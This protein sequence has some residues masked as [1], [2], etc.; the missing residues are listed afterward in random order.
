MSIKFFKLANE[1][2]VNASEVKRLRI[3]GRFKVVGVMGTGDADLGDFDSRLEAEEFITSLCE[4]VNISD[5]S[6]EAMKQAT[7]DVYSCILNEFTPFGDD[8]DM[9][10]VRDVSFEDI[11]SRVKD[12]YTDRLCK[13]ALKTLIEMGHVYHPTVNKYVI[14]RIPTNHAI[15]RMINKFFT[16]H[17]DGVPWGESYLISSMRSLWRLPDYHIKWAEYVFLYL[18]DAQY[19]ECVQIENDEPIYKILTMPEEVDWDENTEQVIYD[20]D[21]K[22]YFNHLRGDNK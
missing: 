6:H 16:S 12:K 14:P 17:K 5:S 13:N 8:K 3:A 7:S 4:S 22:P 18:K 15:Q 21:F 20:V 10:L 11:M 19:V 9:E 1:G 2:A